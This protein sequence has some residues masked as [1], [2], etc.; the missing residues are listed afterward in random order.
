[1]VHLKFIIRIHEVNTKDRQKA[2]VSRLKAY[3]DLDTTVP[4]LPRQMDL[5]EDDM[6]S[7]NEFEI[8]AILDHRDMKN[9][10]EYLVRWLGWT[11]RHNSWVG[12]DDMQ[13]AQ[14][15][16]RKYEAL[17]PRKS[18]TKKYSKKHRGRVQSK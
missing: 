13:H 18:A 2:H 15:I 17:H 1:M 4:Q 7:D 16:L 14:D 8:D 12:M 3:F 6:D 11:D 10:R 9:G 5:P